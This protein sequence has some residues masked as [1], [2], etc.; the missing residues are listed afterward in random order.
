MCKQYVENTIRHE[1]KKANH[2]VVGI[3]WNTYTTEVEEGYFETDTVVTICLKE[4]F[5]WRKL[6]RRFAR[7]ETKLNKKC[8]VSL[9]VVKA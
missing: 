6:Y 9:E 8:G 1:F 5:S 2:K 3:V 4:T 7:L